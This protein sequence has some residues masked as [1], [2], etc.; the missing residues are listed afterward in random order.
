VFFNCLFLQ[1]L[2]RELRILLLEADM[3][4]K[5]LLSK[6][7]DQIWARNTHLYDMV[8]ALSLEQPRSSHTAQLWWP[9][10]VAEF[11]GGTRE[12]TELPEADSLEAVGSRQY[13]SYSLATGQAV[14]GAVREPLEL[15]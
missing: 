7:A 13:G 2:P 6:R 8:A 12:A 4:Y 1:K 5:R 10:R 11:R 15:R 3:V 14:R 9:G